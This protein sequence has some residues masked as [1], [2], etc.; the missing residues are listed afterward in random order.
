MYF[1]SLDA[2]DGLPAL[3]NKVSY[4]SCLLERYL[5]YQKVGV[6]KFRT[7]KFKVS[8]GFKVFNVLK[9]LGVVLS[10]SGN[11][12][13]EMVDSIVGSNLYVYNIFHKSFT[14]V[15]EKGTE[16]ATAADGVVKLLRIL[17]CY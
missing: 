13:T 5:R 8:F 3:V 2:K 9:G 15:N 4:E 11:G 17:A 16:A 1:F 10:F 14:E 12:L 6:S 7:P